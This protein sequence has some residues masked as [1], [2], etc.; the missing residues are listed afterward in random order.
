M[1]VTVLIAAVTCLLCGPFARAGLITYTEQAIATGSLG[2]N[3]FSGALVTITFSGNTSNVKNPLAG[4]FTNTV[5][6]A[7]VTVAGIVGTATFTDKMG[8]TGNQNLSRAGISD[9]T[10]N[11]AILFTNNLAFA[12]Y[13]LTT[14]IGPLS[15]SSV[16]GASPFPTDMG[17]FA[18]I[19]ISGGNSTY[20]ATTATV[21]EPF[22]AG[23]VGISFVIGIIYKGWRRKRAAA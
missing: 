7:T 20:T 2:A 12:D 17:N 5:G 6:V 23:F 21:P 11:L 9:F 8:T 16:F 18:L 19:S 22:S 3:S 10:A 15:G 1:K 13:D 14:A 4:I